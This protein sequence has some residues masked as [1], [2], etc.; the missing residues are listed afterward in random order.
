MFGPRKAMFGTYDQERSVGL[1]L[2]LV[3]TGELKCV[4]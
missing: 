4:Y 3:E 2:L 1:C